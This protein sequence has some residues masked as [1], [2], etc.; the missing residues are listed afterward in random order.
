MAKLYGEIAASALLT[1]DKSFARALGQPLDSTEIY[2]SLAAAQEYAAGLNAYVGQKIAV[3]ENGVVTH[4]SIEDTNGTLKELGAKVV[5]DDASIEVSSGIVSMHDFGKVYYKYIAKTAEAEAHYEKVEV[6]ESTPWKAGLEPRVTTDGSELVIGWFE[7]N[8]TTIE[9]VNNQVTAIQGT[10]A[11]L[12]EAL[13]TPGDENTEASGIYKEIDNVEAEVEELVDTIGTAEDSLSDETN[14]LWANVNDL[15]DRLDAIEIPVL[16]VVADDNVLELN[17]DKLI[18]A[19]VSMSY[20]EDEKAIK[21]YGKNDVVLGTVDATPFIKDGMLEDVSYD[22]DSNTLTFKWNTISGMSEDTVVLSDIIEPYTAGNGLKLEGNE[23]AIN[24]LDGSESFLTVTEEGVKLAGVQT[25]IDTAKQEAIND[26]ASKYATIEVVNG[27]AEKAT[28]LEGYGITNAYTKEETLTK[29]EEKIT[30]VNGGESA[31]EVLSQLNSYKEITDAAIDTIQEKLET[32]ETEAEKNIIEKVKVNGEELEVN[33]T[34]RSVN[35]TV[36][37]KFSDLSDDSGFNDRITKA[38]ADAAQGISD[39]S[40]ALSKANEAA[41]AAS[42]AQG[43]IDELETTVNAH[44]ESVSGHLARIVALEQADLTHAEEYMALE[45]VVSGHTSTI[46]ALAKQSDLDSLI[47]RVSTTESAIT[48]LNNTTIPALQS[49]INNK[50][51]KGTV[52]TK[53]EIGVIAEGK[54]IVQMIA[55]AQSAATY[56]DKEIRALI[57]NND[58][59]IKAEEE[60]AKKAEAALEAKLA[61]V[62]TVMDFVGVITEDELPGTEGYQKGDVIIH[63]AQEYVFDGIIWQPFGD[64][65]I[66]AALISELDSKIKANENAI[67]A[68]NDSETGILAISKKYTDDTIAALPG[69]LVDN[70]TVEVKA[71]GKIGVKAISTDLLVQG[72]QELILYGGNAN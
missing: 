40:I 4:Y 57:D 31:G 67:T 22:A 51:E 63:K 23:F 39:A 5:A 30:E 61:N 68:I 35:V 11:D 8:P 21:L 70:I 1:L 2:Y 26:A 62:G 28:T 7:P 59:S 25:A 10:V 20:D 58:K 71:D 38:Q 54:T 27:K 15:S 42:V 47:S 14:T 48:S 55:D 52:Y 65:S 45:K 34:D 53:D 49:V 46:A 66:H 6:S 24:L 32:V 72:E 44:I 37:T 60:R 16:G 36:P 33:A 18:S 56:D 3:I 13:G 69:A 43:E 50:V 29:I 64:A 9:G 19:T 12:E 17:S 41:R